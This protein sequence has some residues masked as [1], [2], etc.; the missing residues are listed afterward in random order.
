MTEKEIKQ[1][2][3][4]TDSMTPDDQIAI[5]EDRLAMLERLTTPMQK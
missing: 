5:L 4:L 1:E 3:G 2:L